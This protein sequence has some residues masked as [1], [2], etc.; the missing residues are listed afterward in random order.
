M[1]KVGEMDLSARESASDQ[2]QLETLGAQIEGVLNQIKR[3]RQASE[4]LQENA[5]AEHER[6][7]ALQQETRDIISH[8]YAADARC[9]MF[10]Q[11]ISYARQ[12][13]DLVGEVGRLRAE[14]TDVQA[15]LKTTRAENAQSAQN[16]RDIAHGLLHLKET[17]QLEREKLLLQLELELTKAGRRLPPNSSKSE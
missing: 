1:A 2:A 14:L 10:Q 12:P 16:I 5:P 8:F 9:N 15:E 7:R 4:A 11:L 13:F 6:T 17:E 3:D